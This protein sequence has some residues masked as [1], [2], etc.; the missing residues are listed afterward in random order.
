MGFHPRTRRLLREHNLEILADLADPGRR[1]EGPRAA[2]LA[3]TAA[4]SLIF[5]IVILVHLVAA[6]YALT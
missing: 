4:V 3:M 6:G 2:A 1:S 5:A